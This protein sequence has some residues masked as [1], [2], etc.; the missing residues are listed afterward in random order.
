MSGEVVRLGGGRNRVVTAFRLK[1]AARER[2]REL[3]GDDIQIVD[4][5]DADGTEATVVVHAVSPQLIERL[6]SAFPHARVV[7]IEVRDEDVGLHLGG[8]VTRL[9][10][11][12][13]DGYFVA[14]SVEELAALMTGLDEAGPRLTASAA[15]ELSAAEKELHDIVEAMLERRQ[16]AGLSV[17]HD[18]RA[19]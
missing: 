1:R 9:L 2:L 5:R 14:N 10:D 4:I 19:E 8:P 13:A 7:V 17:R 15:R 3:L 11:A 16:V 18:E 12:G 6:H